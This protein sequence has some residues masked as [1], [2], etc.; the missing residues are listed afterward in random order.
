VHAPWDFEFQ[1]VFH[2]E[3]VSELERERR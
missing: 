2:D 1:G 3:S